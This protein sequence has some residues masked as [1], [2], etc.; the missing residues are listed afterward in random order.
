MSRESGSGQCTKPM[1]CE[2][3]IT[4]KANTTVRP[5]KLSI[6]HRCSLS[7][8][9]I[10]SMSSF[11]CSAMKSMCSCF[12]FASTSYV[13]CS[14]CDRSFTRRCADFFLL[15]SSSS[16]PVPSS[17]ELSELSDVSDEWVRLFRAPTA[18]K[19]CNPPTP[20]NDI[21]VSVDG[22]SAVRAAPL[23]RSTNSSV[24]EPVESPPVCA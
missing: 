11:M 8:V 6:S 20:P 24:S 10:M 18:S 13:R 4:S 19:P 1:T 17:S 23:S 22:L 2:T 3:V 15:S 7:F 5:K 16:G 21:V 9:S 14:S 12:S